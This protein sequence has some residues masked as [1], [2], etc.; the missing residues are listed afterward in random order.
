[1]FSV[2]KYDS[3]IA[4]L[5]TKATNKKSIK[6]EENMDTNDDDE[7]SDGFVFCL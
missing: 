1:M 7:L 4:S 3:Q 5:Q 6:D 2:V